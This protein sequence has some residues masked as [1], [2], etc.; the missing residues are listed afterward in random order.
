MIVVGGKNSSNTNQLVKLSKDV[1]AKVYHIE[2]AEEIR[3]EWF[4]GVKS[5]G[6]T[7]GASTPHW[8]IDKV[9]SKIK[10]IPIRR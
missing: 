3:E 5:V 7:G 8:I 9:V 10:E 4:Q 2:T 6:I 1:C